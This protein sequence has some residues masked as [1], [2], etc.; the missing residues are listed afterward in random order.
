VEN[1][2]AKRVNATV[3]GEL[4]GL[5]YIGPTIADGT[6]VVVQG[7]ALLDDGDAVTTKE[8]AQ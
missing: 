1:G 5:L 4:N 3:L 2:K 7:R 6:E 8:V